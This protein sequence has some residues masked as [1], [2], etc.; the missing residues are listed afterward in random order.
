VGILEPQAAV[1]SEPRRQLVARGEEAGRI[2]VEQGEVVH[3]ALV[4]GLERAGGEVA[5]SP[6][7]AR[8]GRR[9]RCARRTQGTIRAPGMARAP[10]STGLNS[11]EVNANMM[12]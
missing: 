4:G 6:A 2:V 7:D 11:M 12:S 8:A 5:V 9:S 10:A 1:H 3:V